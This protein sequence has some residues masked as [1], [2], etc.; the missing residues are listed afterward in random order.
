VL[1]LQ[2]KA[3]L[4][5]LVL[6]QASMQPYI[7]YRTFS[8]GSC[9]VGEGCALP[10]TR[11][12]LYFT[13]AIRNIGT[14]DLVMGRPENNP[15]FVWDPCH[16][17]YHFEQFAIYRLLDSTGQ[18]V[19][20]SR[21]FS[22]CLEDTAR[23]RDTA[24]PNRRYSCGG[25]QGIQ[26]G[27]ADIYDPA[28]PCQWL[29][30]TGLPGGNYIIEAIVDPEN[31][32]AESNDGNNVTRLAVTLPSDCVAPGN[33]LFVNA[34]VL[35][36]WVT[37]AIAA[38]VCASKEAGE[39]N[40]AG[41]AG[42]HSIWYQWTAT[43]AGPTMITTIGSDFDTL[44]AV[45]TGS[46]L[47]SL[48]LIAQNDDIVP[49]TNRQSRVTFNAVLGTTYRIAVDGWQASV[50]RVIL[51]IN[52][53]L[54]DAFADCTPLTGMAGTNGGY[55]I[56]ASKEQGEPAHAGNIGG[57]SVWYCW[58]A[59]ASTSYVFYLGNCDYDSTMAVY[60][61]NSVS[62]LTMIVG[63]DNS[64][65][66]D[67]SS[68]RFT[69]INGQAYRIAVDGFSGAT[70]NFRLKWAPAQPIRLSILRRTN[71]VIVRVQADPGEYDLL[72]SSNFGIWSTAAAFNGVFPYC[73]FTNSTAGP[74]PRFYR[75]QGP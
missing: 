66:N 62:N 7:D 40:H 35:S 69:A 19:V 20:M 15:L 36:G 6:N 65:G 14:G 11:R 42:G 25:T 50:G 51:K 18:Q 29:D 31:L 26:A 16:G 64:A 46:S 55:N 43:N 45:Y 49:F 9:E 2:L 22:F 67:A 30:I 48:T 73:E 60:T 72:V 52:P 12:L 39:P 53:P 33:D 44:L 4:P 27:W 10:G 47:S 3:A 61:G 37:E 63:D 41:D 5:D 54:N 71:N 32:I 24:N 70:G 8:S 59:P 75:V 38:N 21:K 58:T 23:F 34:A 1:V 68:V 17:H 56:G 57:H 28:V 74:A 13:G